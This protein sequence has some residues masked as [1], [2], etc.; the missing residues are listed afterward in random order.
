MGLTEA[1]F[2]S[3]ADDLTIATYSWDTASATPRGVVQIAHG[4]AEHAGRYERLATALATAGS[5]VYAND[6]RG[7]GKSV[8]EATPLGS[9][10]TGRTEVSGLVHGLAVTAV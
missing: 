7:H 5:L 4:I 2:T 6:P 8:N 3:S 10:G 1:S 9:F